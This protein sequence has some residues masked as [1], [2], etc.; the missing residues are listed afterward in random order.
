MEST[1][2]AVHTYSVTEHPLATLV[3]ALLECAEDEEL[4]DIHKRYAGEK[5]PHDPPLC[6]TLQHAFRL[7]GRKLP[8]SWTARHRNM[9]SRYARLHASEPY[10]VWL[11]GYD[12]WVR[13]VVLPIVGSS[14]YYQR[15]PTLRVAMVSEHK[16]TIGVHCDADYPDHHP[17][18]INFW[19]PL[20]DVAD[21]N[22]LWLESSPGC[23]DFAPRSL[24]VGEVLQFDGYRVRHHTQ[25]NQSG[26]SRVSFDL[27]CIPA[28]ALGVDETPPP[29]IGEY[30]CAY[31]PWEPKEEGRNV[32]QGS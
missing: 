12:A 6:P 32:S 7:G 30:A 19:C 10:Q 24:R 26:R 20:V 13:N 23:G 3:S 8:G 18:E 21:S 2:E 27:R 9:S 5:L 31:M 14:I 29:M 16:A 22:A 28:A 15:P 25:P 4:V 1:T 11:D 17:R